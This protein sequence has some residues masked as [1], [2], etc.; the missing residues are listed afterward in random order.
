[1][2]HVTA[3]FDRFVQVALKHGLLETQQAQQ[4]LRYASEHAI[5]PSDAALTLTVLEPH[6]VEAVNLLVTP[7]T[8]MSGYR[9]VS[10]IGCGAGGMVFRAHQTAL[11]RDVALKTIN[12]GGR[13]TANGQARL[14]REAQSLARLHHPNVVTAYDSGFRQGRFC[15]AM[16]LVEGET[17][18]SF[19]QRKQRLNQRLTWQIVRQIASGLSHAAQ[20]GITHRDIKPGNILLTDPPAGSDLPPEVPFAKVVDFG[21]AI[22]QSSSDEQP[23]TAAGSALGTPAYMAPEQLL[24]THVDQRADIYALGATAY[25]MLCGQ[26]PWAGEPPMA[27]ITLKSIGVEG[28]KDDLMEGL[29]TPTRQ[30]FQHMTASDVSQRIGNYEELISRIS[31]VL[32][33]PELSEAVDQPSSEGKRAFLFPSWMKVFLW[34]FVAAVF[35]GWWLVSNRQQVRPAIAANEDAISWQPQGP[36]YPLFDGVGYPLQFRRRGVWTPEA[37]SDGGRVLVGASGAKIYMPLSI[38]K[39]RLNVRLEMILHLA[40]GDNVTLGVTRDGIEEALG[41]VR[42]PIEAERG[43]D[44]QQGGL[45]EAPGVP[46]RPIAVSFSK[47]FDQVLIHVDG[48]EKLHLSCDPSGTLSAVVDCIDGGVRLSDIEIVQLVP[49]RSEVQ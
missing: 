46:L 31:D 34:A 30:L 45:R 10:L 19:I 25:H 16:E 42:V 5:D 18:G 48:Q 11:D 27:A 39:Q 14:Q 20:L 35:F 24:D 21:L 9:L 28:W 33:N 7:T 13:A 44:T 1:M 3:E 17:L 40:A 6:E 49:I 47:R 36:F 23:L 41:S 37:L 12:T 15:I 29:S 38:E 4:I 32:A 26:A 8:L 22:E 43:E 2:T